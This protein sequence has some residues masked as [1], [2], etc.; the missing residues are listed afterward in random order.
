MSACTQA[1]AATATA[2]VDRAEEGTDSKT[3]AE[4]VLLQCK[5]LQKDRENGVFLMEKW[6]KGARTDFVG[7][8]LNGGAACTV[9]WAINRCV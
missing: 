9:Q 6:V 2:T 5:K 1:T 3:T 4:I 7:T 8:R